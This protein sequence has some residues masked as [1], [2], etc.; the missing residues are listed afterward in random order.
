VG[1]TRAAYSSL[2]CNSPGNRSKKIEFLSKKVGLIFFPPKLST[3][4]YSELQ[5]LL[6][7]KPANLL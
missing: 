1:A 7:N 2:F 6:V 4:N 5:D 3:I